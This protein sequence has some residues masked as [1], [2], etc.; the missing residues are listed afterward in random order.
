MTH[1]LITRFAIP[2]AKD[3][4][5]Y[6]RCTNAPGWFDKRCDLFEKYTLPSI[7]AQTNQD[8]YWILIANPDFPGM[9]KDRLESYAADVLWVDWEWDE[10]FDTL[11]NK[12]KAHFLMDE[13]IITSR[14]DNDDMLSKHFIEGCQVTATENVQWLSF[15]YGYILK[16]DAAYLRKYPSSPFVSFVERGDSPITVYHTSHIYA[17]KKYPLVEI[18]DD[19]GWV[20]IDH[21][22][23]V[24]NSV[25]SLM[26]RGK[27]SGEASV[28]FEDIRKEF[29]Q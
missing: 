9:D 26:T 19:P 25:K 23:N 21:G 22:D 3:S 10:G 5:R 8:F 14:V 6:E 16:K 2:F 28:H 29:G 13:W 12:L 20:Q 1:F 18:S 7:E 27:I 11:G 24:K 17:G 15:P 4:I